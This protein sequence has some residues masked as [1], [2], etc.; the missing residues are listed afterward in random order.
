MKTSAPQA[1]L[2]DGFL[3][4]ALQG[5]LP[6]VIWGAHFFLS[7]AGAEV[8]C[9]LRLQRFAFGGVTAPTIWLWII[10]VAAIA[11]LLVVTLGPIRRGRADAESGDSLTAIRIGV[12]ILALVGVVWSAVPIVVVDEAAVCL[13]TR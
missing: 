9:A 1:K 11:T 10:S 12:G 2:A 13:P 6:L 3:S 4:A 8:A 5:V 7:Y